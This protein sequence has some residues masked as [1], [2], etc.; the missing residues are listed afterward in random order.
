MSNI[1]ISVGILPGSF[2]DLQ[3]FTDYWAVSTM[4]LRIERRISAS[5]AEILC[6]YNAAIERLPEIL[7]YLD[8]YSPD[9]LIPEAQT[10]YEL[11]LGLIQAAIAVEL[12]Q[13]PRGP[14]AVYPNSL[15]LIEGRP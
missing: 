2:S 9:C 12:H 7:V 6:F 11:S 15:H 13:A 4:E 8:Q 5:Y 1:P 3:S 10:L 14:I